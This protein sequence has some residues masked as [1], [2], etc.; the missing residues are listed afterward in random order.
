M[1]NAV[2]AG[3]LLVVGHYNF[4]VD[5]D[6]VSGFKADADNGCTIR[7]GRFGHGRK[8]E[9]GLANVQTV[10]AERVGRNGRVGGVLHD[11][12]KSTSILVLASTRGGACWRS[13]ENC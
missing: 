9:N 2:A 8:R 5:R 6:C 7:M 3:S 13:M 1:E 10:S 12:A 11:H 4:G